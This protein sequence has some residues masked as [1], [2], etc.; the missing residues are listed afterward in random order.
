MNFLKHLIPESNS[1][2]LLR[3]FFGVYN[4]LAVLSSTVEIAFV[5]IQS[6]N[7]SIR[8]VDANMNS[9]NSRLLLLGRRVFFSGPWH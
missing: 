8:P 1:M 3:K 2:S 9:S 5:A 4:V 7:S 6:R